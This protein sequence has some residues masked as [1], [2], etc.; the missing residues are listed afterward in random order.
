MHIFKDEDCNQYVTIHRR[1]LRQLTKDMSLTPISEPRLNEVKHIRPNQCILLF[2]SLPHR[3]GNLL[4]VSGRWLQTAS[5]D[6]RRERAMLS[7]QHNGQAPLLEMHWRRHDAM[8]VR[9]IFVLTTMRWM[10]IDVTPRTFSYRC[11]A[12]TG[13]I[14]CYIKLTVTWQ[15]FARV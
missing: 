10:G 4:L 8:Q 2:R 9:S 14:K 5:H 7:V 12:G 3:L 13:Q 11:C 1:A 15:V 6:P